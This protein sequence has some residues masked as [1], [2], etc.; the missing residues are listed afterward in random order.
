MEDCLLSDKAHEKRGSSGAINLPYDQG[1]RVR[2]SF[3]GCTLPTIPG[4]RYVQRWQR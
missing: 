4:W 2:L 1:V 3:T